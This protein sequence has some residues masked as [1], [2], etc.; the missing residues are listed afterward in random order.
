M[1]PMFRVHSPEP[2]RG[3]FASVQKRQREWFRVMSRQVGLAGDDLWTLP[4]TFI[5][6]ALVSLV[7]WLCMVKSLT[8]GPSGA[9]KP[10]SAFI[11]SPIL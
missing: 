1:S 7:S 2:T 6:D 4:R 8:L 9:S 5:G 3:F 10:T 11:L